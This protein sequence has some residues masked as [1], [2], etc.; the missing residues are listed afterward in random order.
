MMIYYASALIIFGGILIIDPRLPKFSVRGKARELSQKIEQMS[1]RK[2]KSKETAS[3]WL[4]RINGISKEGFASRS[5]HEARGVYEAIGQ[6][7]R[8]QKTLL[9]SFFCGLGGVIAGLLLQ[10][11][12][13]SV[14]LA[15]GFYFLPLWL[16]RFS[17][18]RYQRFVNEELETALS[19][20]TTSY[21]RSS[22]LL[23]AIEE[24][25]PAVNEP[26]RAV[27]VSFVNGL[28]YVDANAPTQIRRMKEMLDNPL[29]SEWCDALL[30]CQDNHLLQ[31]TLKPI[32]AKF[33]ILKAQQEANETRMMAPL[34]YAIM[35]SV[36]VVGFC[37]LMKLINDDWYHYLMYTPFGQ[38]VLAGA[39]IAVFVTLNKGI[40]L[41]EP[42]SYN[43]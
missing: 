39:A 10:N 36:M 42:I 30:L 9:T 14:V 38:V 11:I 6:A 19:L 8:Y 40:T 21:L 16:T 29:F 41:S 3:E 35:M 27:F 25:L 13:L 20:V 2:R 28:K 31:A 4:D 34:R 12:L 22:D 32:V 18:Y 33:A 7:D 26:V 43:V 15:V 1:T 17:L 5:Y 23:S 24:N 37:P